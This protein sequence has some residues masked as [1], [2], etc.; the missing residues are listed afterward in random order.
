MEYREG[1]DKRYASDWLHGVFIIWNNSSEQ[2]VC[3]LL[4]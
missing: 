3:G 4:F 2:A 1:T